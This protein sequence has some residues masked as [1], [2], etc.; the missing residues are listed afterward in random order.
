M[1]DRDHVTI[2]PAGWTDD[3]D[4][5]TVA[6][7]L[8]DLELVPGGNPYHADSWR[9]RGDHISELTWRWIRTATPGEWR[10]AEDLQRVALELDR[11][12]LE[13]LRRRRDGL[14]PHTNL[15]PW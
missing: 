10:M 7:L 1:T 15:R 3:R 14:P 13:R 12:E 6:L 4:P 5:I 9:L 11:A 8:A 2:G